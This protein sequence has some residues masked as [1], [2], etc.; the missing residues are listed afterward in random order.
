[1]FKRCLIRCIKCSL[2]QVLSLS[3]LTTVE[4]FIMKRYLFA[5]TISP[6]RHM[7][8]STPHVN[9]SIKSM[10]PITGILPK[11]TTHIY[12]NTHTSKKIIYLLQKVFFLNLQL[13][14]RYWHMH[15]MFIMVCPYIDL[16]ISVWWS[17]LN[18]ATMIFRC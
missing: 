13:Q 12:A 8:T 15:L 9:I 10:I 4:I 2:G 1:M 17:Y 3:M 6:Q 16:I 14:I 5:S 11:T 18:Q 7:S